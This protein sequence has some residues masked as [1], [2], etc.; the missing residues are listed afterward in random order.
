MIREEI[1]PAVNWGEKALK[2]SR[3]LN[4]PEIEAHALNNIGCAKMV[5]GDSSGE[6]DLK[7]S[8]E[9]SLRNN[10]FE[11]A[12]R[13]YINY[14][15]IKLQQRELA[16][17]DKYFSAG[18]EY[19]NEK[20][21]Y[22]LSLCL[23]GHHSK[24]KLHYGDW[25]AAVELAKLVLNKKNLPV[26]NTLIPISIVGIVRA[27][28]ND[29]GAVE[30]LDKSV[31]LAVR[32]GEKE[33]I[34]YTEAARAEYFWLQNKLHTL[35]D[36]LKTIYAQVINSNNKWAIGEIA[37][38][39]WKSG[40]LDK[41]PEC[42][43]EPFLLQIK[44]EWK[45]AA[46]EWEKLQCPYEQALALSEGDSEAMKQA[47]EIFDGL[48]ASAASR[49]LKQKMREKGIKRIPK[50]PRQ[51]TRENPAGLTSRQ[52]DVLKL[53]TRGLSNSEIASSLFISPKTVDHHIC[54]ILAKLN[55][56]SRTEAAAYVQGN[57]M[58]R[59]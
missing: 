46:K 1:E 6:S 3:K 7:R 27:R 31:E 22:T 29:P 26:A 51:S 50:G 17:A 55:L 18:E 53:V 12:E 25:D 45:D 59:E 4:D 44:G 37:Y 5:T 23:A 42:I 16:E 14:A 58:L 36:E 48:G 41:I 52:T 11:H 49:L 38:W 47:I 21:L 40:H 32:M 28:R 24:V 30:L 19:G 43:A 54:A 13:A 33:K 15:G 2:L 8:L 34:V 35:V 56:R 39:L 9:I 20:D 57:G 10:F